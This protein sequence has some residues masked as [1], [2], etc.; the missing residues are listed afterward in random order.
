MAEEAERGLPFSSFP[1]HPFH[2]SWPS[3]LC[4]LPRPTSS[5][6]LPTTQVNHPHLS[7]F[8]FDSG[9]PR[10]SDGLTNVAVRTLSVGN[11]D[12]FEAQKLVVFALPGYF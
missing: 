1:F 12:D 6:T 2:P 5:L 3:V 8:D 4:P 10:S 7:D 11:L 9:M